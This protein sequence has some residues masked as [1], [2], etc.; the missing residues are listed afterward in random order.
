MLTAA[1][2][3]PSGW[4]ICDGAAVSRSTYSALFTSI[5]TT[6][7]AGNGSTTFNLPNLKG[8]VPVGLDSAQT[9]FDVRGETGGAKTHTLTTAQ[10]PVHN[11][12]ASTNTTGAHVHQSQGYWSGGGGLGGAI[13]RTTVGGDPIDTNSLRSAGDHSHTV[14]VNNAGSGSAHN[15]LQPYLVMHYIIKT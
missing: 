9:E 1:A 5:G 7:G 6:Y 13:S 4:L 15:N 12:T 3:A 10:M 8:R 11:H 14:T 2:T